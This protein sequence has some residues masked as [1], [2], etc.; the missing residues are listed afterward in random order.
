MFDDNGKHIGHIADRD[1]DGTDDRRITYVFDDNGKR[2]GHTEDRDLDGNDDR[3]VTYTFD[4]NGKRTGQTEDRDLDGADDRRIT[5]TFDDD[6]KRIG[7]TEDRDLDGAD[8]RRIT[9][10][11]D[12]NGKRIGQTEDRDL[13]GV[14]DRRITGIFDDDGKRIGQI[15]DRDLDGNAD[16]RITYMFDDNGKHI[17]HIADRDLDGNDDRRITYMF[18]DNGKRIGHTE[19]RDLDGVDDRRITYVFD[20]NGKRIGQ[21][22]DKGNDGV[23]DTVTYERAA[24]GVQADMPDGVSAAIGSAHDDT[25]TGNAGANTLTGGDGADVLDGGAG[26]DTVSYADSDAAVTVNL[27]TFA[28]GLAAGLEFRVNT[29]TEV[30]QQDSSVTALSDGGFVVTWTSELDLVYGQRYG[31]DGT[32][33]GSEFQVNTFSGSYYFHYSSV[34]GLSDGGFVVTWTKMELHHSNK[35]QTWVEEYN[36]YGQRFAADGTT[37]GDEFR[38]NT[39]TYDWQL[40]TSVTGLSDGGFVVTWMS[41]NQDGSSFGIYGQRFAADGTTVGDEFRV[42]TETDDRQS[43]P[44]VTALSDGGFVVTWTS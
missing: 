25:L 43:T 11:F 3:R 36:V 44:S 29:Y 2:I 38:V 15:E 20:D 41:L 16:R 23:A 17:G 42:N 6:G 22:M 33:T 24:R 34:T 14:D 5:Y 26:D 1:L 18:D 13:D 28:N 32:R 35:R 7:Q 4:D 37:V 21:I 9:Y 8:D 27:N 30:S 39:E 12:D 40:S 19:D 10:T 31:A